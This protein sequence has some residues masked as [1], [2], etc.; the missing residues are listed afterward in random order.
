MGCSPSYKISMEF[1]DRVFE[2]VDAVKGLAS[3]APDDRA[4]ERDAYVDAIAT[5]LERFIEVV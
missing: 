5:L 4:E 2:M 1:D 3:L